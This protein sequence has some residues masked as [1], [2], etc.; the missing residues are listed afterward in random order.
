MSGLFII[1]DEHDVD[2]EILTPRD[3]AKG[4]EFTRQTPFGEIPMVPPMPKELIYPSSEIEARIKAK[5]AEQSQ[6]SDMLKYFKIDVLNQEKTNFCWFNSPTFSVMALR[7]A[8]GLP[9]IRLSPASGAAQITNY[10]NVGGYGE[11]AFRWITTKGIAPQELWPANAIDRQYHTS[12]T[13]QAALNFR[14]HEWYELEPGNMDQVVS[15]LLRNIPVCVG[16]NWW[17]HEVTYIDA[18]WLD[19][20]LAILFANSWGTGWGQNGYG[21]LRGNRMKPSDAVAPATTVS[22][23]GWKVAA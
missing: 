3:F 19:G 18:L 1:E 14:V 8:Q 4:L 9:Y 10:R 22:S 23:L 11:Q 17:G 5:Q 13:D 20:A 12:V 2:S 7:A 16:L 15:M 21:I 6:L